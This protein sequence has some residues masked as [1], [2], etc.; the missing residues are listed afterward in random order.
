MLKLITRIVS[1]AVRLLAREASKHSKL[2]NHLDRK[3]DNHYA[4]EERAIRNM[5]AAGSAY[6]QSLLTDIC[7]HERHADKASALASQLQKV[8][9]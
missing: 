8:L 3:F 1:I 5:E 2:A 4:A 7:I 6:R 9:E